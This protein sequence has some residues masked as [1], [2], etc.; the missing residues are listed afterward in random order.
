MSRL[1][2]HRQKQFTY[3]LFLVVALT[4]GFIVFL[5]TFGFKLLVNVSLFLNQ[6]ANSPSSKV[7]TEITDNVLTSLN[8]D[9]LPPATSSARLL[10]SGSTVN[11]DQVEIYVN[12]ERMTDAQVVGD[13]FSEEIS[14]L[15]KGENT[16]YVIAKSKSGKTTKKS[17][18]FTVVLKT[19]KPNLEITE[20]SDNSKS[21]KQ[22]IKIA[23]K[24]DKETFIRINGQPAVVDAQGVFQQLYKLSEGEN[25]IEIVAEDVVGNTESKTITVTYAK[26]D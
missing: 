5:F 4:I 25:K 17:R 8:I 22:E 3:Q 13:V 23:G 15:E 2:K 14:G 10:V 11:F 16:V 18:I 19:E 20:P 26:D 6:L 7:T 24:T 12:S 9:P 1:E 21:S